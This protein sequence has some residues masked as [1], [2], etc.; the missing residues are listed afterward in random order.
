MSTSPRN[1][2]ASLVKRALDF[3]RVLGFIGLIGW[4]LFAIAASIGQSSS[5]ETWGVDISVFSSI[6]IDLEKVSSDLRESTGVRDPKIG[7]NAM[8]NIDT[9]SL[10]AFYI[11]VV[12]TEITGIVGL[13]ILLKLRAVFASLAVGEN[14]AKENASLIRNVGIVAILWA[15]VSPPLQYFANRMILSEYSLS[16]PGV[17]LAPAVEINGLAIFIGVSMLVLAGVLREAAEI[18]ESQQLT[19]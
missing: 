3:F 8:L 11:F 7:G 17:V 10:S 15:L 16:V 2:T 5:P 13:I 9:S 12:L 14:F 1:T 18:H 6:D 4:P 19:I